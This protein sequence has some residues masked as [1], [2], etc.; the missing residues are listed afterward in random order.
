MQQELVTPTNGER[1]RSAIGSAPFLSPD[2][3]LSSPPY[4]AN[5]G[6]FFWPYTSVISPTEGTPTRVTP[7]SGSASVSLTPSS[8]SFDEEDPAATENRLYLARLTLQYQ[9]I[10][11]RY[12]LCLSHLQDAAQEAEALRQENAKLRISNGELAKR[13]SLLSDKQS[14]RIASIAAGE[15]PALS[16]VDEFRRLRVGDLPAETSPT[17]VLAFQENRFARR[18]AEKRVLMPKSISVRSSGYL[19]L[20]QAGS[21]ANR[22]GRLRVSSPVMLGS[23]NGSSDRFLGTPTSEALVHGEQQASLPEARLLKPACST[24]PSK[25]D[26]G[27][28]RNC[29]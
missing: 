1:L 9:E 16:I 27:V 13:L 6:D 15:H 12:E 29:H 21:A 22:N 18:T 25:Q 3:R 17:S 14:H 7:L 8:V 11:E 24:S 10:A 28:I 2:Q 26:G 19:K 4:F 5:G 20:N 23:S